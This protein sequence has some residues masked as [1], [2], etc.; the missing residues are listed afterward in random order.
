MLVIK[1][2]LEDTLKKS[3]ADF[4]EAP[5]LDRKFDELGKLRQRIDGLESELNAALSEYQIFVNCELFQLGW[6][7]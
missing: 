7:T 6:Q 2:S 4:Y 1:D 5:D 3:L